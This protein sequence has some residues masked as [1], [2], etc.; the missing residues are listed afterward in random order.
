MCP[1]RGGATGGLLAG[2]SGGPRAFSKAL[3]G[4]NHFWRAC[5]QPEARKMQTALRFAVSEED[6]AGCAHVG[7]KPVEV[8]F[9]KGFD[10]VTGCVDD[11]DGISA[12]DNWDG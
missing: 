4:I 2:I 12:V 6:G 7:S 3:F 9:R 11:P 8:F 10:G 1:L 5:N